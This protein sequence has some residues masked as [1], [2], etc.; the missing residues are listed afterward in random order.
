M[1]RILYSAFKHTNNLYT[2]IICNLRGIKNICNITGLGFGFQNIILKNFL[3]F[4]SKISIKKSS[5]IFFQNKNDLNF[6]RQNKILNKKYEVIPGSGIKIEKFKRKIKK[7]MTHKFLYVG[8]LIP[9][10]GIKELVEAFETLLFNYPDKKIELILVGRLQNDLSSE[11]LKKKIKQIKIKNFSDNLKQYFLNAD[12][13]IFPS[14]REGM[15]RALLQAGIFELPVICSNVVG[16]NNLVVNNKNGILFKSKSVNDLYKGMKKIIHLD[17]SK[18]NIMSKNLK[19]TIKKNYDEKIVI[20]SYLRI[21]KQL[22]E[23]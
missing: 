3:I 10:K 1:L 7:I 6:F 19:K 23:T 2:S 12:Y 11:I 16:N 22:Y 13:F 17:K 20:N 9:D 14:Y 15:S 18:L 8:R 5:F 21:I 4:L